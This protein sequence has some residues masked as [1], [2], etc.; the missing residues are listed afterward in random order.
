MVE[1][2]QTANII[3]AATFSPNGQL[4]VAG[5]YNGQCVFY[6]TD[7]RHYDSACSERFTQRSLPCVQGLKYFTQVECKNRH[8]K[9]RKGKK[10]TGL[11]FTPD[12]K[13][14]S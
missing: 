8:G 1:W 7:V 11:Q 4:A 6:S 2:A 3:T 5:L 14:V 10:V 12:G 9:F 13:H